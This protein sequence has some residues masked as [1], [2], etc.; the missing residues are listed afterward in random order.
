MVRSARL[1]V[2]R[3]DLAD[4]PGGD[5]DVH[6]PADAEDLL[7]KDLIAVGVPVRLAHAIDRRDPEVVGNDA[8]DLAVPGARL[9]RLAQLL[10][11]G[12][13]E[14]HPGE[15][16]DQLHQILQRLTAGAGVVPGFTSG[17]PAAQS[18]QSAGANV[19]MSTV[20]SACSGTSRCAAPPERST[21]TAAPTTWAPADRTA[22]IVSWTEP[23]VV[24]MSST[25]STRSSAPSSNPRR[26]SRPRPLSVRSV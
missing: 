20:Q 14:G 12:G 17:T 1:G 11:D 16:A 22:S 24:M 23:P 15:R 19:G 8:R 7:R 9:G 21:R 18:G 3:N 25:T 2:L 5:G 6:R 10:I 13:G 4:L 26:N